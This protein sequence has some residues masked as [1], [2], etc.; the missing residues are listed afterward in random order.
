MQ[1][2]QDCVSRLQTV[3]NELQN[4]LSLLERSDDGAYDNEEKD[5]AGRSPLKQVRPP[6]EDVVLEAG[7]QKIIPRV[8]LFSHLSANVQYAHKHSDHV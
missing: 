5:V 3:N 1:E 4:R 8:A 7:P 6:M 2:L